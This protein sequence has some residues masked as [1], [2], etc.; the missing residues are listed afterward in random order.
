MPVMVMKQLK[1]NLTPEDDLRQRAEAVLKKT[2]LS[3]SASPTGDNQRLLEEIRIYQIELLM[4]N[5][6]LRGAYEEI[7]N[8]KETYSDL[9]DF[10]PVGYMILDDKNLIHRINLTGATLLGMDRNRLLGKRFSKFI[11]TD[12][13]DRFFHHIRQCLETQEKQTCEL[14]LKSDTGKQPY[15]LMESMPVA[16]NE[17][18]LKRIRTA[19][20]EITDRK[21]ALEQIR[22]LNRELLV[23]QETERQMISRELHDGIIQD[24]GAIKIGCDTLIDNHPE[25][26]KEIKRKIREIS[27]MLQKTIGTARDLSY[28]LQP[29]WVKNGN[30]IEMLHDFCGEYSKNTGIEVSFVSAGIKDFVLD[31]FILTNT[32]RLIQEG[33]N[34][35]KK[36]AKASNAEATFSY[37]KPDILLRIVD[38]GIGFDVEKNLTAKP[39]KKRMGLRSMVER[40]RLLGGT[41]EIQSKALKG[42]KIIIRIPFEHK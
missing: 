7:E 1:K 21:M 27:K 5:E 32:Y 35:I 41:M 29:P 34:N 11:S 17:G 6:E 40:V 3:G 14:K 23:S 31:D 36:H 2:P 25:I 28:Q 19:I 15:V 9:Y 33:L 42:T 39:S 8:I 12:T 20:I 16:D 4:Q 24:L 26:Q 13:V 30:F 38:N 37:H 10:S 22:S 18:N